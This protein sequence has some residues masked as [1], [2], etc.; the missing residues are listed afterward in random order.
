MSICR[1]LRRRIRDLESR[2][3]YR[4]IDALL[5]D[6]PRQAGERPDIGLAFEDVTR[7]IATHEIPTH[8]PEQP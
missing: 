7:R 4:A 5:K 2:V 3:D 8:T 6:W 1:F